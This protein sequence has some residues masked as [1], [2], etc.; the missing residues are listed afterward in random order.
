MGGVGDL[1]FH[2]DITH[3]GKS[4]FCTLREVIFLQPRKADGTCTRENNL[5]PNMT[6]ILEINSFSSFLFFF[7]LN[8]PFSTHALVPANTTKICHM[9]DIRSV[10]E[11]YYFSYTQFQTLDIS[12]LQNTG[13][14]KQ[15]VPASG[16]PSKIYQAVRHSLVQIYLH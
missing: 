5:K 13:G 3:F 6:R 4:S 15:G 16:N 8:P 2:H 14:Y 12:W 9:V 11:I 10:L 1:F 7:F